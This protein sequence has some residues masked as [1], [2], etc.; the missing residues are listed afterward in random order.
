M[1]AQ[2]PALVT[3]V[4][5]AVSILPETTGVSAAQVLRESHDTNVEVRLRLLHVLFYYICRSIFF[6]VFFFLFSL[7]GGG[8]G[9]SIYSLFVCTVVPPIEWTKNKLNFSYAAPYFH[10]HFH[11][12]DTIASIFTRLDPLILS[13]TARLL[14]LSAFKLELY[15]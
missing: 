1:S 14:G 8:G 6:F 2:A 5:P 13:N 7:M 15:T 4:H 12:T 9:V 3:W 11:H 10:L